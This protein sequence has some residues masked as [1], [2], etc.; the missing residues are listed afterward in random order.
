MCVWGGGGQTKRVCAVGMCE[1]SWGGGG[2]G[3]QR[4][5]VWW[6]C[7]RERDPAW[8]GVKDKVC[9]M[10][11]CERSCRGGGGADKESVCRGYV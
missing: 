6:V 5:C 9:V 8:R 10:G 3:R 7:V 1:K 4:V 2:G 11:M